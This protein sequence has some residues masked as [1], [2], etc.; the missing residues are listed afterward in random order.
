MSNRQETEMQKASRDKYT[1]SMRLSGPNDPAG[2]LNVF[3]LIFQYENYRAWQ[4]THSKTETRDRQEVQDFVILLR[5]PI[6]DIL[7]THEATILFRKQHRM[8]KSN[9]KVKR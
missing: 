5:F 1:N 4:T 9:S 8:T 2:L 7:Q 3:S 6:F